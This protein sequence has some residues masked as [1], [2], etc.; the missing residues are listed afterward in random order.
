MESL[1]R[2][3]LAIGLC[4]ASVTARAGAF[5]DVQLTGPCAKSNMDV[6]ENGNV[7]SIILNDFGATMPLGE[8]GDGKMVRRECDF[9]VRI[10]FPKD[11]Y[12][13]GLTQVF[14]GGVI[15][16]AKAQ[17]SFHV[18]SRIMREMAMIDPLK[19]KVGEEISPESPKSVFTVTLD[20]KL[21]KPSTC[22]GRLNYNTKMV[23]QANRPNVKNEY[24]IGA[25][26]TVDSELVQR[27]DL[28]PD[29][30]RC[31]GKKKLGRDRDKDLDKVKERIKEL[32][33]RRKG[34]R[35]LR[36]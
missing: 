20:E 14:S 9:R 25:I 2:F 11:E 23:L 16:S 30:Q 35:N 18:R 6:I 31:D 4:V 17:G 8:E 26:D 36:R 21:P 27:I 13:A 19:W 34:G 15:K 22:S 12:L 32:I 33:E 3:S 28:I 5:D 29:W 7:L 1:I 10:T 24:F